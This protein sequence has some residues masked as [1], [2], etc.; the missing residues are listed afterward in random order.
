M[1][2]RRTIV[3]DIVSGIAIAAAN[4]LDIDNNTLHIDRSILGTSILNVGTGSC[5][6]ERIGLCA[7]SLQHLSRSV[8]TIGVGHGVR[9]GYVFTSGK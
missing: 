6:V 1:V 9:L 2:G 4:L 7:R 3:R 8:A 5:H